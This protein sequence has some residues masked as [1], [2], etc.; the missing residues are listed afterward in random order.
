MILIEKTDYFHQWKTMIIIRMTYLS[1]NKQIFVSYTTHT[2]PR[3]ALLHTVV[4]WIMFMDRLQN[5]TA[6]LPI[7]FNGYIFLLIKLCHNRSH[8]KYPTWKTNHDTPAHILHI[9]IFFQFIFL[10]QYSKAN[11]NENITFEICLLF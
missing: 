8:I 4:G 9:L 1:R 3:K 11:D 2:N 6:F 7:Y 10:V 5:V